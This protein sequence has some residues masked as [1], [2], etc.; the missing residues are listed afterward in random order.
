MR[1]KHRRNAYRRQA[2]EELSALQSDNT[3][4]A[5]QTVAK[6][7]IL[8]KRIALYAYPKSDTAAFSGAQWIEFLNTSCPELKQHQDKTC[9]EILQTGPYQAEIS[10]NMLD[11]SSLFSDCQKWVQHHLEAADLS[12][13]AA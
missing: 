6:L 1:L 5:T 3:L 4:T 12:V 9:F 7:N 11:R 13:E 10:E 2:L 8:L